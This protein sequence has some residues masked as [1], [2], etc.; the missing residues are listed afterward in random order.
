MK[1]RIKMGTV[2]PKMG[3]IV[4]LDEIPDDYRRAIAMALHAELGS[5]HRAIKSAMRWTGASER[6]VK[7]WFQGERGPS[8]EHLVS[9]A[10]HSEA[11]LIVLL[12][13]A[14]RVV[15]EDGKD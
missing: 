15:L 14:D 4:H 1:V 8:G 5:T 6:T 7:Y 12:V 11:V 2:V 13:L 10:R 3:T 9:L